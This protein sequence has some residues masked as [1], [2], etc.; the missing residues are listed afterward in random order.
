[1][2]WRASGPR[3]RTLGA[4][5]RC[6]HNRVVLRAH[7]LEL[8]VSETAFRKPAEDVCFPAP[9]AEDD[10]PLAEGLDLHAL[11][12]ARAGGEERALEV[13]RERLAR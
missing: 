4:R 6:R 10:V 11:R 9:A 12:L 8:L 2:G 5:Q 1:M 7:T 13:V 3:G